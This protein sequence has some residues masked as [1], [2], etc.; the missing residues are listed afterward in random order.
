[1]GHY[2]ELEVAPSATPA[3]I[4]KSYLALA[5]RYHPDGL[6]AAPERDRAQAAARMARINAAWSVLSDR[7]RRAAYDAALRGSDGDDGAAGATIRDVSD[8]WTAHDG[9]FD[10]DDD[11]DPRLLDDTPTGAPTLRRSVTFL[12]AIFATA[13]I[14]SLLVGFLIGLFPLVAVGLALLALAGLSFLLIPLLALFNA[15]RA[16]RDW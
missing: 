14:V 9:T 1:M 10:A 7:A 4:R 15:S 6:G 8:T 12:P 16:D 13:G 2:D 11:V 5:R 3:E